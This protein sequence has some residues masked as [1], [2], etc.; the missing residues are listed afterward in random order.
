LAHRR[1]AVGDLDEDPKPR[2][3]PLVLEGTGH[4]SWSRDRR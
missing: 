3:G 1:L 4:I 2:R